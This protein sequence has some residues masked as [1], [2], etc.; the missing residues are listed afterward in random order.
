MHLLNYACLLQQVLNSSFNTKTMKRLFFV[1]ALFAAVACNDNS[2]DQ[3]MNSDSSN[4]MQQP[5]DTTNNMMDTMSADTMH[6]DTM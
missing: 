3:D 5:V 4:M 6:H 2:A 1:A